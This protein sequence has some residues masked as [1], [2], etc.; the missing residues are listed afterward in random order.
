MFEVKKSSVHGRGVF[1]KEDV[2]KGTEIS[3]DILLLKSHDKTLRSH[4][5]HIDNEHRCI[6][7]DVFTFLNWGDDHHIKVLEFDKKN[8]KMKFIMLKSVKKGQEVLL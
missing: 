4:T 6:C 2:E 8:M 3:S 7:L 5:F 1:A